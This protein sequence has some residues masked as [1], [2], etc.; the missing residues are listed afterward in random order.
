MQQHWAARRVKSSAELLGLF[1]SLSYWVS[2]SYKT[3]LQKSVEY[4]IGLQILKGRDFEW[5]GYDIVQV[6]SLPFSISEK[7]EVCQM[8]LTLLCPQLK[9]HY[10]HFDHE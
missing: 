2:D 10:V 4:N 1:C 6:L 9:R 8:F 3:C 5:I 7:H